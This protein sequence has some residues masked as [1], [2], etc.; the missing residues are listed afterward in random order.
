MR[1][2]RGGTLCTFGNSQHEMG[3]LRAILAYHPVERLL[4]PNLARALRLSGRYSACLV[5]G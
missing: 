2:T 5:T 4:T 1:H 3:S